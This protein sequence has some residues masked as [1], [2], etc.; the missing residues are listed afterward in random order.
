[1]A[2]G[3]ALHVHLR[4]GDEENQMPPHQLR[5][6]VQHLG[7]HRGFGEVGHPEDEAATRL[8]MHQRCR[9]TE[10]VG[11]ERFG[12]HLRQRIQ[13]QPQMR[14][15]ASGQHEL[16]R[17]APIREQTHAVA[18]GKRDLRERQRGGGGLVELGIAA[19]SRA[20]QA[21]RVEHQPDRLALFHLVEARHQ[22]SATR[23]GG[24]A[25]VADLVAFEVVAQAFEVAAHAALPAQTHLQLDAMMPR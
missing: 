3:L 16:L 11:F 17:V 20:L 10:M 14:R 23:R 4:D 9:C 8:A 12:S 18:G 1:M 5:G 25:D 6:C 7:L 24:P 2:V 22:G 21:S 19:H 15:A 13:Q